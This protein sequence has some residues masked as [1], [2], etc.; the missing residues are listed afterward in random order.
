MGKTG[1][2]PDSESEYTEVWNDI[3]VQL[4]VYFFAC[5]YS[6]FCSSHD[7]QC[8]FFIPSF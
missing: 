8:S 2:E 7:D 4:F 1:A 6:L 5:L 3:I